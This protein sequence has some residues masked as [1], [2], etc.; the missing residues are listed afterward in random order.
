[1]IYPFRIGHGYDCHKL[2]NDRKLI[3]G[4][5]LI[6][7]SVGLLGHSD[8][9]VLLHAII[10]ALFG[11][12][13]LGDIGYHFPDT[14]IQFQN[15][16]SRQLLCETYKYITAAGYIINNIDATILAEEP[17]MNIYIPKMLINISTDLQITKQQIN[18]KAKTNEKL[19]YIGRKEGIAAE[20]VVL[21]YKNTNNKTYT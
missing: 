6:I 14:N 9:D 11:A 8:A 13:S 10:D 2:V 21:L 7:H 4:G 17:K 19:G 1:M 15:T 5:V 20:A 12:A 3:I 18:I 16:S